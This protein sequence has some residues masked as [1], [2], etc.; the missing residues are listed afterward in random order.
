MVLGTIHCG[1]FAAKFICND[2]NTTSYEVAPALVLKRSFDILTC[3]YTESRTSPSTQPSY[4][5]GSAYQAYKLN[6][7]NRSSWIVEPQITLGKKELGKGK[8]CVCGH[9][10][11]SVLSRLFTWNSSNSQFTFGICCQRTG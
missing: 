10:K 8:I 11:I 3:A 1:I 2:Y 7:S 4:G 9:S 5:I 6:N